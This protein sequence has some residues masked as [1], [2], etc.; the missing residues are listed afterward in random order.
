M[1]RKLVDIIQK[2][3]SAVIG[4]LNPDMLKNIKELLDLSEY[5]YVI[6]SSDTELATHRMGFPNGINE[7]MG[8]E[9]FIRMRLLAEIKL[10]NQ[11]FDLN[12]N[13]YYLEYTADWIYN[14]HVMNTPLNYLDVDG[15]LFDT[16]EKF[17][18]ERNL[19]NPNMEDQIATKLMGLIKEFFDDEANL[20]IIMLRA[21][22]FT[23]PC[24]L[25]VSQENSL[26]SKYIIDS[27]KLF[28]HDFTLLEV[29][30][31]TEAVSLQY[32]TFNN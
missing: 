31:D 32:L 25:L 19:L 28:H 15:K 24:I 2:K 13:E 7:Y 9:V 22:L 27:I 11:T 4:N 26:K 12:I 16:L 20:P 14:M 5:R 3:Q 21:Q 17:F 30:D 6:L 10:I 23:Q 29:S 1:E 18:E 8:S